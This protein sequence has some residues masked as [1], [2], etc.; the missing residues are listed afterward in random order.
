MEP[1][2]TTTFSQLLLHKLNLPGSR[3]TVYVPAGTLKRNPP[4]SK[5]MYEEMDPPSTG[6]DTKTKS[7]GRALFNTS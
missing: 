6:M 4:V 2:T 3:V 1:L 7:A 5:F